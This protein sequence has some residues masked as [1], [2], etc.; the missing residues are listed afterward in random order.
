MAATARS[1]YDSLYKDLI[2]TVII[3]KNCGYDNLRKWLAQHHMSP[4]GQAYLTLSNDL[5]EMM[6]SGNFELDPLKPKPK[7]GNRNK[8]KNK[9][10]NKKKGEKDKKTVRAIVESIPIIPTMDKPDS[11]E[12]KGP[13]SDKDYSVDNG[14]DA[15]SEG[16]NSSKENNI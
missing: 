9:N 7:R 10:K 8:N 14:L 12:D 3:T 1:P 15:I 13:D 16:D 6:N 4:H 5:V 11:V 2:V